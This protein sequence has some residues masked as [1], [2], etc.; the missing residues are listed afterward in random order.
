MCGI[1]GIVGPP[2]A[3]AAGPLAEMVRRLRHRGPDGSGLRS[4]GNVHLGH[5][6]LSIRDLSPLGAQP[7]GDGPGAPCITYNGEV[8]GVD[9]LRGWLSS[10]GRTLRSRTD[11]EV[12]LRL[13][14]E[15]GRSLLGRLNG[16]FAFALW[17]PGARRLLLA[18]DRLGIKPL[19]YAFTPGALYFA[20]EVKAILAAMGRVPP[21]RPDGIAQYLVQG[22]VNAPDTIFA[23]IRSLPAGHLL[24]LPVPAEGPPAPA[25]PEEWWDVPFRGE[26]D[27]DPAAWVEEVGALLQDATSLQ[28]E[29]DV[30]L[31]AFLS[32]GVDSSV[33]VGAMARKAGGGFHTVSLDQPGTALSE[34]AKARAVAARL[35][36][37]HHAIE[38]GPEG[39]GRFFDLLRH[40][41]VPFNVSS[42]LNAWLVSAEARRWVTVALSGDG[43]D[44]L[45]GGYGW[46]LGDAARRAASGGPRLPG[47]LAGLLPE[48][49]RG[50]ARLRALA[51]GEFE[52]VH[53]RD[54]AL[55]RGTAE[56]MT[57]ASLR[58]WEEEARRVHGRHGR[59]PLERAMYFDLKRFL[60]D[61]VLAKVDAASMAV[62]LEV[63]PP[64]LDHRLVELA[65]RIPVE[66]KI[67]DGR[68]KLP[69]R[70][71]L[72]R[73]APA[74]V[75]D[76]GKVGFEA[77]LH[78]W[79]V[80]GGAPAMAR[81]LSSGSCRWRGWLDPAVVSPLLDAVRSPGLLR[82]PR[83]G[84]AWSL[85]LFERWLAGG[86]A[87]SAAPG[88]A[89]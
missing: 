43:G 27:T 61:Q 2:A 7:M 32:G 41:D 58:G 55:G 76:Q 70:A 33:V 8:Y 4:E 79:A 28:M 60:P 10:R 72:A 83:A 31:G 36:T 89:P 59:N 49:L 6:R 77:P 21:L 65:A 29:S 11:T 35:G 53:E 24:D 67:R 52:L 44:E 86:G 39:A 26:G 81:E 85:L 45:F 78:R 20:S 74:A 9:P 64:L 63:R 23:G 34:G 38:S 14:E 30:P 37:V 42:L 54:H 62:S 57:G 66:A 19:F 87:D 12:V 88:G 48:D 47:A 71:L 17:D 46:Y 25:E 73:C 51:R 69:L 13:Y 3:E 40:F 80:P 82:V 22:Y 75:L 50:A 18:R 56:R 16:M 5:T 1:A 68:G 15:V 84:F